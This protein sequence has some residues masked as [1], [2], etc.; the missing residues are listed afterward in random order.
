MIADHHHYIY[1]IQEREFIKTN[2]NIYKIGK[3]K[4]QNTKRFTQ[5]PKSSKL[6]IHVNVVDCDTIEKKLIRTFT[7][8]FKQRT[9]IGT[10]YFQGKV[11]DMIKLIFDTCI[12]PCVIDNKIDVMMEKCEIIKKMSDVV[13]YQTSVRRRKYV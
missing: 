7:E 3:T 9:D 12:Q 11:K 6:I 2:E 13:Y 8:K 5:Y 4:Q 1:L 10:E